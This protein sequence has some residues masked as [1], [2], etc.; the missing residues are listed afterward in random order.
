M[1]CG[2]YGGEHERQ[3]ERTS[4]G[5]ARPKRHAV[6][7]AR[8]HRRLFRACHRQPRPASRHRRPVPRRLGLSRRPHHRRHP[9]R[10]RRLPRHRQRV[11]RL[12]GQAA[13]AEDR[14]QRRLRAAL[15]HQY[16]LALRLHLPRHAAGVAG[17]E[18]ARARSAR[19]RAR[20]LADGARRLLRRRCHRARR[21]GG[22]RAHPPRDAAGS[23]S[24]DARRHRAGLHFVLVPVSHLREPDRRAR[25]ARRDPAHLFRARALQGRPAGRARRGAHR[26]RAVVG[27]GARR[28]GAAA[29][30]RGATP[31][32]ARSR[33]PHRGSARR[34]AHH[35]RFRDRAHGHLLGAGLAAE[36]RVGG[37]RGRFLPDRAV[38]GRERG[39]HH[40]GGAV[41]LLL[42]D[43]DLHRASGLEGAGRARRLLDPQRRPFHRCCA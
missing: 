21:R 17:S 39:G 15:R 34:P 37:G 16:G 20:C 5:F 31:S 6:A 43:D 12:A 29:R 4:A 33:R 24:V 38:A 11:L 40:C 25:H 41:R 14:A 26:H 2:P 13:G 36:H 1:S 42:P 8:R 10:R 19:S 35:L 32:G 27:D 18:S 9:P 23:P 3:C 22:R 30:S 7:R 28:P